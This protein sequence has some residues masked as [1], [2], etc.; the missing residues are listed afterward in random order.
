[1]LVDAEQTYFQAAI[2]HLTMHHLV[3][4]FNKQKAVIYNTIQTYLTV[5]PC[6]CS[7]NLHSIVNTIPSPSFMCDH[8]HESSCPM[9]RFSPMAGR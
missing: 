2:H 4:R 6:P 5:S 1:M 7:A 8:T 3:P 9:L